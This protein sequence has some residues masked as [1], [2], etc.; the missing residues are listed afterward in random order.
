MR[1][2]SDSMF[3]RRQAKARAIS[4]FLIRASMSARTA[5]SA[6]SAAV[7]SACSRAIRMSAAG[8]FQ[9]EWRFVPPAGKRRATDKLSSSIG[10]ERQRRA[11]LGFGTLRRLGE[12]AGLS[13]EA[14]RQLAG[15]VFPRAQQP[16]Q[17]L[18]RIALDTLAG[19]I[20]RAQHGLRFG[21]AAARRPAPP[22]GGPGRIALDA[23]GVVEDVAQPGH[24]RDAALRR[25]LLGP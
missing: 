3:S 8:M 17:R 10:L 5:C 20:G 25:R 19:E 6:A 7:Q 18:D 13:Q 9:P 16:V 2:M 1:A 21:M 15:A 22:P 11:A 12:G 24:R 4:A 14:G 23:E